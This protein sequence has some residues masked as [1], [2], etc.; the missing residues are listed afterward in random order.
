M[1]TTLMAAAAIGSLAIGA[2]GLAMQMKG[3]KQT[4]QAAETGAIEVSAAQEKI[5]GDE[6][7][8]EA[9]KNQL[10]HLEAKRKQMDLLRSAQK[11]R[12]MS[13]ATA[14]AAGS[15]Y[16]TGLQGAYGEVQGQYNTQA[17]GIG[18]NLQIGENIFGIN[19]LMSQH[20]I[21]MAR[22]QGRAGMN[23]AQGAGTSAMGSALLGSAGLIGKIGSTN[24]LGNKNTNTASNA[25]LDISPAAYE[26][27]GSYGYNPG[28][29]A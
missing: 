29:I 10:M 27:F 5:I 6:Q 15:Q 9:Q 24:F 1:P 7:Q 18:Q 16:G 26:N 11:A 13:L 22:A 20:K 14:T 12:A 4:Q 25:P 19:A 8:V 21:E 23:A 3:A 17:T 2:T 28:S